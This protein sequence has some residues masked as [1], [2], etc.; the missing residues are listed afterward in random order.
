MDQVLPTPPPT[1]RNCFRTTLGDPIL[2]VLGHQHG[3]S[4]QRRASC[5]LLPHCLCTAL[6]HFRSQTQNSHGSSGRNQL[7]PYHWHRCWRS[8]TTISFF[9]TPRYSTFDRELLGWQF[10]HF[11]EGRVLTALTYALNVRSDRHSQHD[12]LLSSG[13]FLLVVRTML[14]CLELSSAG[15]LCRHKFVHSN[16]QLGSTEPSLFHW[17]PK[18]PGSASNCIQLPTQSLS[19]RN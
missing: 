5:E 7:C 2:G 1:N 14:L 12:T 17:H 15:G 8:S 10:R 16:P 4:A 19:P 18:T 11:L 13:Q 9:S 3:Q 6:P